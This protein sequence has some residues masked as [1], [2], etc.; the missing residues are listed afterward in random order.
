MER[1]EE[2]LDAFALAARGEDRAAEGAAKTAV[3]IEVAEGSA[4][5]ATQMITRGMDIGRAE[6]QRELRQ[7][8]GIRREDE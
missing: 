2:L 7:L 1:L 3:M 5:R 8:L 4:R 6:L